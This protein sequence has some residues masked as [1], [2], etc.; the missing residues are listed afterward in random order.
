MQNTPEQPLSIN[1]ALTDAV[2]I[3]T[4]TI[5]NDSALVAPGGVL[6]TGRT[7]GMNGTCE[8]TG[9]QTDNVVIV[10]DQRV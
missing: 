6:E 4:V 10:D 8:F 1:V 5:T 9:Y 7:V 3:L 2:E